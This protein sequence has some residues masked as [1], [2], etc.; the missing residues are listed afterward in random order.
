MV[1]VKSVLNDKPSA[2]IEENIL[3]ENPAG[4]PDASGI[5]L[6]THIPKM[7]KIEFLNGRDPGCCIEFHYHSKTHPLK[8][9]QL[10]HGYKHE[11]P[12]EVIEHLENCAENQ[13][14]YRKTPQG[15]I[16]QYVTGKKYIFQCRN[17]RAA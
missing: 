9:Y 13:Y 14:G 2:H 8:H 3:K 16:E 1:K 7:R 11:L 15:E 17:I 12:E 5:V 6:N 4:L 10:F